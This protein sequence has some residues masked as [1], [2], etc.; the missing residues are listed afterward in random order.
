M[1]ADISMAIDRVR[2]ASRLVM[3][4]LTTPQLGAVTDSMWVDLE[5]RLAYH[6]E[7]A[8]SLVQAPLRNITGLLVSSIDTSA[9]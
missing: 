3:H 8:F 4:Q 9:K 5:Q 7:S 1:D 2:L 6:I